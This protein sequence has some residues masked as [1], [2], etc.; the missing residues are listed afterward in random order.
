MI[1]IIHAQN[2]FV[3][4]NPASEPVS[5]H[6]TGFFN[7]CAGKEYSEGIRCELY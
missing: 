4:L 6:V 3:D 7:I 2:V 5:G 1:G